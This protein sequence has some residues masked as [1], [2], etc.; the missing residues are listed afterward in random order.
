MHRV[1]DAL[2]QLLPASFDERAW[3]DPAQRDQIRA[4]LQV[5]SAAA[6]RLEEHAGSRERGFGFLSR[7]LARDVSEVESFYSRGQ[8]EEARYYLHELTQ[9]CV[10]CHSRLPS[11]REFPMAERLLDQV[12]LAQLSARERAQLQ[13]ATRRVDAALTTWESMFS[14]PA[15]DPVQLDIGGDLTDYLTVCIRVK[16]DLERPQ[17]SLERLMQRKDLARYLRHHV[18]SWLKALRELAPEA[19]SKPTLARARALVDRALAA[20]DFPGGRQRIVY[21]LLASS[22]LH[23]SVDA[24]PAGDPQLAEAYYLLGVIEARTVDSYWV[25]QT[26]FHLEAA[27]REAPRGPFAEQAYALLEEYIVLGH[28]GPEGLPDEVT[29]NL[30]ELRALLDGPASPGPARCAR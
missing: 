21:D 15:M 20:S 13:V 28:G 17:G 30:A 29:A 23:R 25:P 12:E 6:A 27:V 2:S 10:A 5:L 3:T 26:E 16:L 1:F 18:T 8:Y 24:A 7:S 11:A 9:N 19:A 4:R 14:D 22:M